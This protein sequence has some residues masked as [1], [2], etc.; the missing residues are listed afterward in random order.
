MFLVDNQIKAL[1]VML[2]YLDSLN[3]LSKSSLSSDASKLV[4]TT[5]IEVI[6]TLNREIGIKDSKAALAEAQLK[7]S[8]L[9]GKAY[10]KDIP[11]GKTF[12]FNGGF[13]DPKQE[14]SDDKRNLSDIA[15]DIQDQSIDLITSLIKDVAT[16]NGDISKIN[17]QK[18]K[19]LEEAFIKKL[20]KLATPF[21]IYDKEQ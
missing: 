17:T 3:S 10:T 9:S 13:E 21:D 16:I 20:K 6:N 1:N 14:D 15:S 19:E 18:L 12:K 5:I 4:N 8:P 11:N 7:G 2:Q